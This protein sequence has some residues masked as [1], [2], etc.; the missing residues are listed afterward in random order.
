MDQCTCVF[1]G[2][3]VAH[4]DGDCN[5]SR[6]M[7][8]NIHAQ[9]KTLKRCPICR[10]NCLTRVLNRLKEGKENSDLS[11]TS[12][13]VNYR[14]LNTEQKDKRLHRLHT[15]LKSSQNQSKF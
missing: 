12:S 15:E 3:E 10:K 8:F 14:Y 7:S 6:Q 11:K 9:V 5:P 13:C 1:P 4:T 2:S